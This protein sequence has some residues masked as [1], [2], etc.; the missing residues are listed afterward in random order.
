MSKVGDW[1]YLAIAALGSGV[2]GTVVGAW[3]SRPKDKA[4]VASKLTDS[5]MGMVDQLQ[6]QMEKLEKRVELLKCEVDSCEQRHQI[7]QAQHL[8]LQT[9]LAQMGLAPPPEE[10]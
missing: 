4:D 3:L 6:E 5:A 10:E 8:R 9:Y 7:L 1:G 2:S